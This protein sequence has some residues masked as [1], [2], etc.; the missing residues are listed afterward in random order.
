MVIT[1]Y[2]G[3]CGEELDQVATIHDCQIQFHA[4]PCTVCIDEAIALGEA[5]AVTKAVTKG[6]DLDEHNDL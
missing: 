2:C 1:H 3:V 6:V 5:K 4:P